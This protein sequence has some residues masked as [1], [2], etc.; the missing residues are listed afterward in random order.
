MIE[1]HGSA[2]R[3]RCTRC[4]YLC[5]DLPPS[6]E[7]LPPLCAC[8][9]L[10]RPDVVWFGEDLPREAM[11]RA[12]Q[13]AQEGGAMLIVGTS[14]TVQPAATLPMLALQHGSALVEINPEANPLSALA[15]VSLRG[16]AGR[17]LPELAEALA[18][19]LDA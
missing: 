5:D 14:A 19:T 13:W 12:Q 1:L 3:V 11:R 18:A 7:E 4:G 15:Q 2:Q 17:L 16:T 6:F 10:L 8:G 9:A